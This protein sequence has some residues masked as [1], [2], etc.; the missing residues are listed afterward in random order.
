MKISCTIWLYSKKAQTKFLGIICEYDGQ[1]SYVL[2]ILKDYY[3]DAKCLRNLIAKGHILELAENPSWCSRAAG[4]VPPKYLTA[5]NINEM[6]EQAKPFL[7]S[8]C[9]SSDEHRWYVNGG[10][11]KYKEFDLIK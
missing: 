1:D 11:G 4:N 7:Y 6:K 2:P 5:M 9:Y 3:S 8:Y 10:S